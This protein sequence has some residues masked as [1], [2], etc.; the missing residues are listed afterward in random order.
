MLPQTTQ[1]HL[2]FV[3]DDNNDFGADFM[4]IYSGNALLEADR[5]QL[6]IRYYAP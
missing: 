2:R 3:K 5:P 4:K 1:F 6:I